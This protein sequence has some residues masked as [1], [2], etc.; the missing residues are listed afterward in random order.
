M[1]NVLFATTAASALLI[2]GIASAQGV[3][4]FGDARMGLGYN[5]Q[6]NGATLLDENGNTSD[7]VRVLSRVRFGVNMTGETD[8]GITFGAT[9]RADNAIGGQGGANGQN[10]GSVF[11]S[12]A[13]GT[14]TTGDTNAA[15]EQWVGDTVG[16]YSLTGLADRDETAFISNGGQFGRDTGGN[17]ASNPASRPTIRYD[18]D[19]MG[20]GVSVS[21]NRDL[22]DVVVGAGYS[23]DFGGGTWTLGAGYNNFQGFT[24]ITNPAISVGDGYQ[25]SLGAKATYGAIGFGATYTNA[26]IDNSDNDL[27]TL[28]VG[29]SYEFGDYAVGGYYGNLLSRGGEASV[30]GGGNETYQISGQYDLGGG[31][32]VNGAIGQDYNENTVADFG[33][34]M[35]F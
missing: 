1:K 24:T 8:S 32:T 34:K 33:I 4:L 17:F 19:L 28:L 27:Q 5:V 9:I 22:D 2:G 12:G 11:V 15:D 35:A 23:A 18:F 16:D 26:Q 3:A 20:F 6:N 25:W 29:V 30:G 10:E 13:F 31:A 7:D 14:L 21:S